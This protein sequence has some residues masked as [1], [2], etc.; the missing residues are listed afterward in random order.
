[1]HIAQSY[2][3]GEHAKRKLCVEE[4][5]RETWLVAHIIL[6]LYLGNGTCAF[7]CDERFLLYTSKC[8][9]MRS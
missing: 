2:E 7:F 1:M 3:M 4:N 5:F 6:S 9:N 8:I